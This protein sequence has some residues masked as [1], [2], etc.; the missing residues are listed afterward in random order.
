VAKF[1]TA[2]MRDKWFEINDLNHPATDALN[3][4]FNA[5]NTNRNESVSRTY[6]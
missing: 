3:H 5:L 1:E 6:E 2:A 4:A